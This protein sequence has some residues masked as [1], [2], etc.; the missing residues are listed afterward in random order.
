MGGTV[1]D[2]RT[3]LTNLSENL[4]YAAGRIRTLEKQAAD[5]AGAERKATL[6]Q[7][8]IR[9]GLARDDEDAAARIRKLAN[10]HPVEVAAD[11]MAGPLDMFI[12]DGDAPGADGNENKRILKPEEALEYFR[13]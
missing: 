7:T 2:L 10:M 6:A 11:L 13:S 8:L 9:S 4:R 3:A 12:S 5:T 1:G